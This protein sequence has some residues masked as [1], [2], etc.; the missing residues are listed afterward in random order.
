MI[1]VCLLTCGD[2]RLQHAARAAHSFARLNHDRGDLVLL[3]VDG[4]GPGRIENLEIAKTFG[5]N[6]VDAPVERVGQIESFRTFLDAVSGF[7]LMLWLEND[8]ESE[9]PIPRFSFFRG[10]PYIEQFRLYGTHKMRGDGPRAPAGTHVIGTKEKIIWSSRDDLP[11]WE[12]G[13]CH[14]GAG[15]T[16]VRP[17]ILEPFRDGPR[18]KDV[19]VSSAHLR[20]VRPVEN[21]L[22]HIGETT[23]KGFFG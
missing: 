4:G 10:L 2:D 5:F 16:I 17:E 14:W 20:T 22:W 3:H 13:R 23:T 12:E 21:Y 6:T 7:P 8:W 11:G 18:L 1:A 9:R 15:G 19:I